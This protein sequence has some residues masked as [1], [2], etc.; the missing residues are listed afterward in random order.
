MTPLQ[1]AA[2]VGEI[3]VF[4]YLLKHSAISHKSEHTLEVQERTVLEIAQRPGRSKILSVLQK[5]LR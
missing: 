3:S 2:Q 4:K 1:C 5:K